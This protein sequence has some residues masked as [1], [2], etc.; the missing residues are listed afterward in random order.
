MN[1]Q[2]QIKKVLREELNNETFNPHKEK[3]V[4]L[5]YKKYSKL[6]AT[7]IEPPIGNNEPHGDIPIY[8][9]IARAID[10]KL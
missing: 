8:K 9:E 3:D 5:Y 1:L 2:E 7:L 6:G 4:R 10:S